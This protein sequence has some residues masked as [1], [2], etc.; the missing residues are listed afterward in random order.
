MPNHV[1]AIEAIDGVAIEQPPT[2]GEGQANDYILGVGKSDERMIF[3]L[4][5]DAVL[6]SPE[7]IPGLP[8]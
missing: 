5:I 3:M 4:D 2:L 1:L 6:D 7:P 8:S